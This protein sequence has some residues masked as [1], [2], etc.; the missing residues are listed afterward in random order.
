MTKKPFNLITH[1]L[2]L[3][4]YALCPK[5]YKSTIRNRLSQSCFLPYALCA[6]LSAS[7]NPQSEILLPFTFNLAP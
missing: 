6:L 1:F 7:T 4:P 2:C 5:L 3:L